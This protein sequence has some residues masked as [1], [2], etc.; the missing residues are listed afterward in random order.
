MDFS[1]A[2]SWLAKSTLKIITEYSKRFI[3]NVANQ[4]ENKIK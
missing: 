1:K 2:T 3:P 4:R